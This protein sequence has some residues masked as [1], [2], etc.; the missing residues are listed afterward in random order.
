MK[1]RCY[2]TE[3]NGDGDDYFVIF[4][5]SVSCRQQLGSA[6]TVLLDGRVCLLFAVRSS[7]PCSISVLNNVSSVCEIGAEEY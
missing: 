2:C 5:R 3:K 1:S 7:M 6:V 4:I